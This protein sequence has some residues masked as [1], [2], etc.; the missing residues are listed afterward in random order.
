MFILVV[1]VSCNISLLIMFLKIFS[2]N[3]FLFI[4][5][6][7]YFLYNY[8]DCYIDNVDTYI[9]RKKQISLINL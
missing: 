8:I 6:L 2:Q 9:E 7:E 5:S 4:I 1:S 3:C